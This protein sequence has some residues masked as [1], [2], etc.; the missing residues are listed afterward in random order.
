MHG[1]ACHYQD[2]NIKIASA[3]ADHGHQYSHQENKGTDDNALTHFFGC[4]SLMG[5]GVHFSK[6]FKGLPAVDCGEACQM[7]MQSGDL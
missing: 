4:P 2:N 3:L 6:I 1:D 5:N 7:L